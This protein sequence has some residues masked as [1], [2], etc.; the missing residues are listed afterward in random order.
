LTW[1]KNQSGKL[2]FSPELLKLNTQIKKS[3]AAIKSVAQGKNISIIFDIDDKILIF[4][5]ENMFDTIV[6]N[7]VSN[8]IKFSHRDGKILISAIET[9]LETQISVIDQGIGIKSE[10][11]AALFEID[12]RS[13]TSGTEDEPGTGF[14]LILCNDFINK[15]QGKIWLK[16]TLGSGSIFTFSLPRKINSNS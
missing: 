12:K 6:R 1:G 2:D 10:R 5:D 4:A 11:Q 8:A 3:V 7:L 16:S 13:V 9:D 15:H 14:G